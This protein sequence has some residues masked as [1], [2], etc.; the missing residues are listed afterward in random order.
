MRITLNRA[1]AVWKVLNNVLNRRKQNVLP[2]EIV[3]NN[4]CL[5]GAELANH[6]NRYFINIPVPSS[7]IL[8]QED[9]IGCAESIFL[10]PTDEMEIYRTFISLNNS[11]SLDI[12]NL[13]IT[14][15]KHVLGSITPVLAHTFNLAMETGVYPKAMK[16]HRECQCCLTVEIKMPQ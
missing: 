2:E 3:H 4:Q 8:F 1:D 5:S 14:P 15:I 16:K 12:D 6:F 10:A 9:Q 7:D 13:Q 11:K